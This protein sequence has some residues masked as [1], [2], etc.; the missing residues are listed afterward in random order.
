MMGIER[1]GQ[2]LRFAARSLRKNAA[3]SAV[4][5]AT[6]ALGIGANTAIFTVVNAVLLRPLPYPQ[7]DRIVNISMAWRDGNLN[8]ALTVPEFQFYRDH[9]GAF[10]AIA[11]F[12][13]SASVAIKRG[14]ATEWVKDVRVTDGFFAALGVRPAIGRG[15]ERQENAARRGSHRG[16]DRFA[17]AQRIRLGPGDFRPAN[18]NG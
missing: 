10:E 2:D 3:F 5:I 18:R 15:I 12:R 6:F 17:V 13:G 9:N 14:G 7:Q 4:A 8:A 11:G 1:F 16:P